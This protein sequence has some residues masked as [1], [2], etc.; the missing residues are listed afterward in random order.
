MKEQIIQ[1]PDTFEVKE[2]K[3]GKIILV[4]KKKKLTY[5]DIARAL[6]ANKEGFFITQNVIEKGFI[7]KKFAF[8]HNCTSQKQAEKLTATNQL[9]NVAKYLNGDWQPNWNNR[10]EY[11]YYIT[12]TSNEIIVDYLFTVN[13]DIVYF[14]SEEL[15]KKAIDI[16]GEAVIKL[17]FCTDY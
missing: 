6:F 5:N 14:K 1:I 16:L 17:A 10:F 12:I 9:M 13:S 3:D 8:G 2:I 15:A 4:E 11:K 7:P